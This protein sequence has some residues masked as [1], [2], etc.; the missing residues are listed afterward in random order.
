MGEGQLRIA[1]GSRWQHPRVLVG[2]IAAGRWKLYESFSPQQEENV[3]NI[4][5]N[6][7][8]SLSMMI[9]C[10]SADERTLSRTIETWV[11]QPWLLDS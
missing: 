9:L 8:R 2:E 11:N 6:K 4:V 10:D 5:V 1:A 3:L 7:T